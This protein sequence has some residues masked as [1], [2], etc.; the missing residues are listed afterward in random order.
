MK[1]LILFMLTFL[2]SVGL[3]AQNKTNPLNGRFISPEKGTIEIFAS[4]K[5]IV[6]SPHDVNQEIIT[7]VVH[8]IKSLNQIT[9]VET[10]DGLLFIFLT[11]NYNTDVWIGPGQIEENEIDFMEVAG[12]EY[13]RVKH[14]RYEGIR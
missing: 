9:Y 10:I 6:T 5:T 14:K 7:H 12:I 1:N 11:G 8:K 3:Y 13:E 4:D 2:L